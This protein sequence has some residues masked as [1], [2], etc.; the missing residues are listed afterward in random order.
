MMSRCAALL[1][2]ALLAACGG[3]NQIEAIYVLNAAPA[4]AVTNASSAQILVPEPRALQ[5]FA[6]NRIPVKPS[7][8]TLS[9]YPNVVLQDTVPRVLQSAVL[10]TFQNSGKV[11]AVG[12]PGQSL[13]INF[14][15]V[16]EVRAFQVET[17]AGNRAR[18][19]IV[20]KLLNDAN[21][22]LVADRVFETTVPLANDE[23]ETGA[24]GLD[25]ALQALAT[26]V[27]DWTLAT[28]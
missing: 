9:Y 8:L 11:R 13:L 23:V 24:T 5:A 18:V 7:P 27:V 3:G 25:L 28:I 16:T 15:V 20:A 6:S 1:L 26:D 14:Q 10:D 22:R 21:G 19:S 2:V 4:P 17:F 12:V